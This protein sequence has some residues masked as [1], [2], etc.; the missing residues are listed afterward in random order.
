MAQHLRQLGLAELAGS[1]GAVRERGQPD[2]GLLVDRSLGHGPFILVVLR[3][4]A[5]STHAHGPRTLGRRIRPEVTSPLSRGTRGIM[6]TLHLHALRGPHHHHHDDGT[7]GTR[8]GLS[9][10]F[11][12]GRHL[13]NDG[14]RVAR[15]ERRC[16]GSTT[17]VALGPP[18]GSRVGVFGSGAERDGWLRRWDHKPPSAHSSAI[19]PIRARSCCAI[20]PK[21]PSARCRAVSAGTTR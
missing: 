14:L 17:V 21:V 4:P 2:S 11:W 3:F 16:A 13:C 18:P 6:P 1:A 15:R 20:A 9:R 8:A 12:A 7:G 5:S 19:S 10:L